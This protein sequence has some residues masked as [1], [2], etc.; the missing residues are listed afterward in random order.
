MT[1]T[2]VE[3]LQQDITLEDMIAAMIRREHPLMSD[4]VIRVYATDEADRLRRRI[5]EDMI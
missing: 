3:A 5:R 4:Q 1:A 2:A